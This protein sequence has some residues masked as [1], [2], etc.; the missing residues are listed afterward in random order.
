MPKMNGEEA[1][2]K[3]RQI[4]PEVRIIVTSGYDAEIL[5]ND[6]PVWMF[7]G[8]SASRI[9]LMMSLPNCK[10]PLAWIDR[11]KRRIAQLPLHT[12]RPRLGCSNG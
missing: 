2:R 9:R 3:L 11:M 10:R 12:G 7:L 4:C 5:A 6:L 8:S 1:F